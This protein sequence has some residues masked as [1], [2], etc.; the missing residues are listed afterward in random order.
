MSVLAR[1]IAGDAAQNTANKVNPS[2]DE[3]N[4]IDEPAE[5]NTWHDS[6][7]FQGMKNQGAGLKNKLPFGNKGEA[8]ESMKQNAQQSKDQAQSSHEQGGSAI[9]NLKGQAQNAKDSASANM[10]EEDKQKAREKRDHNKERAQN[11]MKEKL[12]KERREQAIYRLKKMIVEI[13]GHQDCECDHLI[14][15][16][17]TN[18]FQTRAPS[19]RCCALPKSTKAT[20][21]PSPAMLARKPK[22]HTLEMTD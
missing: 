5:D 17:A 10:S 16:I 2:E 9:D 22:V 11:Y 14:R 6:P 4:N 20:P 13:Q 15:W 18:D 3:L 12:P 21:R 1:D 7:D 19:T 8:K